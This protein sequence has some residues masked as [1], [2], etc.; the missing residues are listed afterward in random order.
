MGAIKPQ[1]SRRCKRA[2]YTDLVLDQVSS[3]IAGSSNQRRETYPHR[4]FEGF[5]SMDILDILHDMRNTS[6]GG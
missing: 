6:A 2:T 1:Y 3:R 4:I 5:V